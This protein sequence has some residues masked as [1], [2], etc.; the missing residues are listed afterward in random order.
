MIIDSDGIVAPCCYWSSCGNRNPA[1]GN[2]NVQTVEEI[3][4]GPGYQALRKHMAA[5]N[6]ENAG[7][8]NCFALKQD[9][10]LQL[11]EDTDAY[12]T[13]PDS[14]Y[15]LNLERLKE[16]IGFGATEL[17]AKPTM[18]AFAESHHCHLSCVHCSQ[19]P[20]RNLSIKRKTV[21]EEVFSISDRLVRLNAIGGEAFIQPVWRRFL[22]EFDRNKNPFLCFS[23]CTSATLI[24]QEDL[25]NLRKF[26]TL[27]INISIDGTQSVYER[28]RVNASWQSLEKYFDRLQAIV[29]EK[30]GSSIGIS[31]S[32][33]KSNI[34]ALPDFIRYAASRRVLFSIIPVTTPI[35]EALDSFNWGGQETLSWKR[36]FDEAREV[37]RKV[38]I[39]ALFDEGQRTDAV[40]SQWINPIDIVENVVDYKTAESETHYLTADFPASFL[41]ETYGNSF[42]ID[43]HLTSNQG[44]YIHLFPRDEPLQRAK[45]YGKV[46][47]SS[48]RDTLRFSVTLPPGRYE[49]YF[50][51]KWRHDSRDW[52]TVFVP[53]GGPYGQQ[54]VSKWYKTRWSFAWAIARYLRRNFANKRTNESKV[55][56]DDRVQGFHLN[57][58]NILRMQSD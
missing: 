57:S 1:L 7:C 30:P 17:S 13:A 16:E 21:A 50:G 11:I 22:K 12:E 34:A 18:I 53:P 54:L 26:K 41:A 58:E 24:R 51:T 38:W 37:V 10:D 49:A 47:R 6:L 3:W 27:N 4:N 31:M 45:F 35:N 48:D 40:I 28:V 56:A 52:F 46:K 44:L 23:T 20:T 32:V 33:M 39:P 43:R 25:E 9:F 15:V 19:E 42:D 8:A 55:Y 36:I 5:G 14:P 29:E 2:V